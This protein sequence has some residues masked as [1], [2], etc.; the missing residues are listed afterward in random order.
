MHT[1]DGDLRRLLDEPMAVA[2]A[3]RSHVASC[4]TCQERTQAVQGAAQAA[5]A[6]LAVAGGD[7]VRPDSRSALLRIRAVARQRS[8]RRTG[9][10]RN[11]APV[12]RWRLAFL[13]AAAAAAVAVSPVGSYAGRLLTIFEPQQVQAVALPAQP[14]AGLPDLNA[15]GSFRQSR[16]LSPVRVASAAAAQAA[17][18]FTAPVPA[19]LP[20]GVGAPSFAVLAQTEA[21]FT[22]SAAKAA[23]AAAAAGKP[24]P[25]MPVG[26]DGST[27]RVTVGPAIAVTYPGPGT[28][29]ATGSGAGAAIANDLTV[30][31]V[32]APVVT[33]TGAGA[34]AIEQYLLSLPGVP[35]SL[36]N[37]IRAVR[38]PVH[39]LPLP[40]PAG[41]TSSSV[42]VSGAS[43]VA[44]SDPSGLYN[45]VV[46]ERAG[47]IYAVAGP[48]TA[49]EVLAAAQTV[50]QG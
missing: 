18:G 11:G 15:Y 9:T 40:V 49:Q 10:V 46:W 16:S 6:A 2:P 27:I 45:A 3:A 50:P 38:D 39:T 31:A 8:D 43:G 35:A 44:L 1:T 42:T 12:W 14:Y 23:S 20:G 7:D 19:S 5:Q 25:A 21:S 37:D 28:P 33:S 41:A 34:A 30:V 17:A 13:A 36:A 26:L 29:V 24:A 48:Y 4:T 32:T 22:F 47:R